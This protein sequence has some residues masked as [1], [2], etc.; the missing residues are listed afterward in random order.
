MHERHTRP[1]L[2]AA[3]LLGAL[4]AALALAGP[5][6]PLPGPVASTF[7]PLAEVEPRT[8]IS[9]TNTP[10]DADSLFRITQP[11]SYYLQGNIQGVL[12]KH[13]IEIAVS[14]VTLDLNGFALVGVAGSLDGVGVQGQR[15]N[16]VVRNGTVSGWG[17]DGVNL[18]APGAVGVAGVIENVIAIGNTHIGI[19]ANAYCVVRGCVA[20]GNGQDG[21][22]VQGPAVIADC[23]ADANGRD[24]I[25]AGPS[26]VLTRSVASANSRDGVVA[27]NGALIEGVTANNNTGD[28]LS[29]TTTAIVSGCSAGENQGAGVRT[30]QICQVVRTAVDRNGARGIDALFA[31]IITDCT[32]SSNT[33]D[34]AAVQ[35][36]TVVMRTN[37][38]G[39]GAGAGSGA[40][41]LALGEGARIQFNSVTDNDRGI[42][43]TD[44]GNLILGNIASGNASNWNFIAGTLYGPVSNI[45]ALA[46]PSVVGSG[47]A[48]SALGSSPANP[49]TNFSY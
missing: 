17:S 40:G 31:C 6:D 44:T 14:N 2:L 4:L 26:G 7:K 42:E 9:A 43:T 49:L 23:I 36:D 34:G 39:N 30:E 20:R 32:L 41:I 29:L 18:T 3:L 38:W 11:G 21:I 45:T 24:G 35:N 1:L 48:P 5:L 8:A 19:R 15:D 28:G 22:F 16:L 10:G 13:G 47:G 37:A 25:N 27:A 12:S 33:T 46:S